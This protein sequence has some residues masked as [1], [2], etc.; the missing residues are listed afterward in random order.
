M[1]GIRP[2]IRRF[3]RNEQAASAVEFA[4]IAPFLL[5]LVAAIMAYGSLFA[6]SLSLQQ[7]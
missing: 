5:L 6:T 1:V 4:L 7:P 2:F 3:V